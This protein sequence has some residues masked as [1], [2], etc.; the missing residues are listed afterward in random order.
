MKD[1]MIDAYMVDAGGVPVEVKIR[2]INKEKKY[3]IVLPAFEKATNALI[4]NLRSRVAQELYVRNPEKMETVVSDDFKTKIG[5]I[6]ERWIDE[7]VPQIDRETKNSI[8]VSIMNESFGLGE[9]E[10]LL[11]DTNLEE[12]VINALGEPVRAYH[13]RYGWLT[14]NITITSDEDVQKYAKSIARYVGTELTIR[15]PLLDAHLPNGDRINAVLNPLSDKGTSIT[16]RM[17]ARDPWTLADFVKN[18]TISDEVLALIWVMLQYEM[19]VLVSGGTGSGKTS[20]LNII[21]P[22]IQPNQ[23]IISIE[24]TRELQLPAFLYWYPMRT[25]KANQE[26]EGEISMAD[27]L[28]N[29]LRMRPDRIV[30]GEV[31]RGDDAEILF[32]AMHT[33]H[34]VYATLHADTSHQTIRRLTNPPINIHPS[35]IE[36][37]HLNVVMFRDR[38]AGVRRVSQVAEIIP[39][40][41]GTEITVR[42]NILYKW[43]ARTDDIVKA[44]EDIRLFQE[45]ALHTGFSRT[46]IN[47]EIEN[48]RKIINWIVGKN[49]RS[50]QD[51]GAVMKSYYSDPDEVYAVVEKN[52]DPAK[53]I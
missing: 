13:R 11:K 3:F 19:N 31:R 5:K 46:E 52:G 40:E 29:S 39:T 14:T 10:F 51:V 38:R 49:L 17:F 34:S 12:I 47:E 2:W 43:R 15:D 8:I 28:I 9:I 7:M 42:P 45:L 27:L 25:R 48:K 26:G 53:I 35:L 50:L 1:E 33:G 16:I 41:V 6:L 22:F 36:A 4:N 30:L 24:D 21:L 44:S 20:L 18:K 32:E 37:I 23:R